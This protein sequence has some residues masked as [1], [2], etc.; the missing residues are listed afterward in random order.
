MSVTAG[1]ATSVMRDVFSVLSRVGA[2]AGASRGRG[3][4]PLAYVVLQVG[5]RKR[6][7]RN[8][9]RMVCHGRAR[10]TRL[11]RNLMTFQ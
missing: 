2:I 1:D 6:A 5:L 7:L 8:A 10:N 3:F 11:I 9:R 4:P